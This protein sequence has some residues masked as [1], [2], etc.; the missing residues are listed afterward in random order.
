MPETI[1]APS[2][3]ASLRCRSAEITC[4]GADGTAL[5]RAASDHAADHA[6]AGRAGLSQ[7]LDGHGWRAMSA[8]RTALLES[9]RQI[10]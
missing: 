8:E 3:I 10:R 6:P 2:R 7:Q 9:L 5:D 4:S 1:P